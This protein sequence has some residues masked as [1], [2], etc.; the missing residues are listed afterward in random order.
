MSQTILQ[1]HSPPEVLGRVLSIV[2]LSI[3]GF[4]PL[5]A[6]QAG[7]VATIFDARIAAMYG[8]AVGLTL[9]ISA[10]VFA[11]DFRRLS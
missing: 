9:A 11:K 7:Q 8:C 5:G 4:I 2:T 3:S 10:F 6:L 1:T